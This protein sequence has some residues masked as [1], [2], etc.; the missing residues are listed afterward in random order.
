MKKFI[1]Y[2]VIV[3]LAAYILIARSHSNN[4][5]QNTNPLNNLFKKEI[6][7]GS[8]VCA[9]FPAKFVEEA[10]GKKVLRTTRFDMD[11]THV[12]DYYTTEKDFLSIHVENLSYET[13]KKGVGELGKLIKQ[14]PLIKMEH[15]VAWQGEDIYCIFLRLNANKF[16]TVDRG[17]INAASNEENMKLA[18]AVV[19]RIQKGENQGLVSTPTSAPTTEP[20]KEVTKTVIPLPQE[21]DIVRNF[22][23]LINEGKPSDAVMMM[24]SANTSNDS[25]KQMW[26]VEF[27]AFSSVKVKSIESS[28][29]EEWTADRHTYKVIL[30]VQMKPEAASVQPIPN[31]GF[32]NG[33]NYR[34]VTII[35]EGSLWKVEGLSTGP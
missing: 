27:N 21:T 16:I 20:I 33:E 32:E 2:F 4:S 8:D 5:V 11:G 6:I 25:N 28:M 26:G 10:S 1:P 35:K 9:E 18:I 3:I 23:E 22:F 34:W 24:S 12:C 7:V 30:D 15:F 29:S 13:Q 31:Y 17:T 19:D 14:D